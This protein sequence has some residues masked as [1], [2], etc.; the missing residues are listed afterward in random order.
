MT[1][2]RFF[3]ACCALLLSVSISAQVFQETTNH[4]A[5]FSSSTD[6]V[7]SAHN[8]YGS[9]EIVGYG[10]NEVLIEVNKYF[11][12]KNQKAIDQGKEE[13]DI[14]I[15][16]D[17]SAVIVYLDSPHSYFDLKKRNYQHRENQTGRRKYKYNFDLVIKVPYDTNVEAYAIN[18]GDIWVKDIETEEINIGNIN[19]KI[20]MENV[21]G[22]ID[23]NALNEDIDVIYKSNPTL[24][25]YFNALNGD[26]NVTVQDD[27]N[28]EVF[29]KSMNGHFYTGLEKSIAGSNAILE[30]SKKGK[31]GKYKLSK[32][33]KFQIGSGGPE[34]HFDLLN[35]DVNLTE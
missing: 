11:K 2:L 34:L 20:T 13:V 12:A 10:G 28:A 25:S 26:V 30:K 17:G 3:S 6:K 33:R 18:D 14:K 35:G 29:F 19:G 22:A 16:E 9:I 8:V 1:L 27:F 32:K 24:D 31:K 7:I 21:S 4:T 5:Q 23:A 15:I